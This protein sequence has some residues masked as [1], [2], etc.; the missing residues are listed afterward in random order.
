MALNEEKSTAGTDEEYFALLDE[1]RRTLAARS[2]PAPKQKPSPTPDK[3]PNKATAPAVSAPQAKAVQRP[4]PRAPQNPSQKATQSPAARPRSMPDGRQTVR[5][6]APSDAARIAAERAARERAERE[7]AAMEREAKERV[8]R[9]R[10]VAAR[11]AR[12]EERRREIRRRV[13]EKKRAELFGILR[14]AGENLLIFL[15]TLSLVTLTAATAFAIFL[16]S[17]SRADAEDKKNII[18]VFNG[19]TSYIA[20]DDMVIDGVT[21]VDFTSIAELCE[22]SLSGTS[23]RLIAGAGED[24]A[25][26]CPGSDRADIN[27]TGVLLGGVAVL[28]EDNTLWLPLSF[29]RDCF[30]GIDIEDEEIERYGE[31]RRRITLSRSPDPSAN[32]TP[33]SPLA[34]SFVIKAG[35]TLEAISPY[36]APAESTP[37]DDIDGTYTFTADLA[38]YE[39]YLSPTGTDRDKYLTLV[40]EDNQLSYYYVPAGLTAVAN[41][42]G[43]S[44]DLQ[45]CLYAERSLEALLLEAEACGF[46]SIRVSSAYTDYDT[47]AALYDGYLYAE[48]YYSRQNYALTGRRFS[49]NAYAVLGESYLTDNY[50]LK[51]NYI[52]SASD[53]GRVVRSY[54]GAQ[55]SDEHQSGLAADLCDISYN[56]TEFADSAFYSW[57]CENAHKFGFILRYPADKTDLTGHTFE[58]WHIRYVGRYHAARIYFSGACLEEYLAAMS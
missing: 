24:I 10:A 29:V 39:R 32:G 28:R 7:R 9:M 19:E 55:G 12:E 27:G 58:P 26:F 56:A 50:I 44:T 38:A 47:I 57:L 1:R 51:D 37:R 6:P 41:A 48:R 42:R 8:A 52:L 13:R 46:D 49:I 17:S 25:V 16:F 30:N 53:A 20:Y 43:E 14:N 22:V 21:Y 34:P 15:C 31:L 23:E 18:C 40:N 5:R 54:F 11:R 45:L 4:M 33:D 35:V 2:S 3:Q 36:D